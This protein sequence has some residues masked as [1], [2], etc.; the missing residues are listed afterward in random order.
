MCSAR[1]SWKHVI[2]IVGGLGPHAHL[3]LE[4]EILQ[5]VVAETDQD[6]PE[7]VLTSMPQTPDR[8]EAWL[9]EGASPV[10]CLQE[11]LERLAAR[12]DFA[13]I[14]CVTAH[15]FLPELRPPLPILDIVDETIRAAVASGC[16]KVGLLATD[17][18]LES[19]VFQR[20]AAR[21]A[22]SMK[23]LTPL[24]LGSEGRRLQEECVIAPI[25]RGIEGARS[26][27]G[28]GAEDR[29]E[30]RR[31]AGALGRAARLLIRE[32]AQAIILGCTEL[33]LVLGHEP[34]DEVPMLDPLRAAAEAVVLI[35]RGEREIP[36]V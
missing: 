13:V 23:V 28:G 30:R 3:Q 35:A 33:P 5:A 25:Y 24:D 2:G 26:I 14:A 36:A 4:R 20:A 11:A 34:M 12:A 17:G 19:G 1:R 29:E 22:P 31:L 27:K 6:Y 9:H 15:A 32:E 16:S 18:T 10:P 21:I 7:W 8:T